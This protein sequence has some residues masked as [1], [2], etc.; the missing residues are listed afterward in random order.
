MTKTCNDCGCNDQD[1]VIY[2]SNC[3][4]ILTHITPNIC[5][6]CKQDLKKITNYCTFCGCSLRKIEKR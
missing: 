2:C 3:G 1:M 5:Y 4:R 6:N